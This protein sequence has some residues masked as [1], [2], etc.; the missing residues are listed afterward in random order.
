MRSLR[1]PRII[2]VAVSVALTLL[3]FLLGAAIRGSNTIVP[4]H[5]HAAVGG[6]TVSFMS[7]ALVLLGAVSAS[8]PRARRRAAGVQPL[9]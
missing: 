8:A 5:Y 6:V 7:A 1:D 4:A 9:L 2:G 3:G